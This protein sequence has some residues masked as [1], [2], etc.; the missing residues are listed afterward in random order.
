MDFRVFRGAFGNWFGLPRRRAIRELTLAVPRSA[1]YCLASRLK[2]PVNPRAFC[3]TDSGYWI[4]LSLDEGEE[5]PLPRPFERCG[6]HLNDKQL[7]GVPTA[8]SPKKH[9]TGDG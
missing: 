1:T 5:D 8:G 9:K 7:W 2:D 4:P 6:D 3:A